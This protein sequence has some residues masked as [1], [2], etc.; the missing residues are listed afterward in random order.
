MGRKPVRLLF[1]L[2]LVLLGVGVIEDLHLNAGGKPSL[3]FFQRFDGFRRGPKKNPGVA[4]RPQMT[5]LRDQLD[6]RVGRFRS[7]HADGFARATGHSVRPGPGIRI[8]ID[9]DEV[10][11]AQRDPTRAGAVDESPGN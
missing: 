3:S 9:V 4:P 11:F 10:F 8:A 1:G 6:V 7:D 5:P 2:L